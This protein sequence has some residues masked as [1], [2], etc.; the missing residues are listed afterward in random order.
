MKCKC[1]FEG[2]PLFGDFGRSNNWPNTR[3]QCPKCK[4]SEKTQFVA[5]EDRVEAE[6]RFPSKCYGSYD[7]GPHRSAR[8]VVNLINGIREIGSYSI[9][10]PVCQ[11]GDGGGIEKD[12]IIKLALLQEKLNKD[13]HKK[14]RE[15]AK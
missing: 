13:F 7:Y 11:W 10:C 2:K 4:S 5:A 14:M 1:G 3:Y 15:V 6:L 8:K 9:T 12:I